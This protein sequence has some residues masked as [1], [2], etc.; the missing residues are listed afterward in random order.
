M[1]LIITSI[2]VRGTIGPAS[3]YTFILTMLAVG[4]VVLVTIL[5]MIVRKGI[6]RARSRNW[7]TAS[8]IIDL[9]SVADV[10]DDASVPSFRATLTYVY[11]NPEEQMGDYSRDF[12]NKDEADAWANSY[13]G[14]T[15]KIYVDPRDPTHSF[16]RDEDL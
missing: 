1:T 3:V 8:A 2:L 15:V 13:K 5:Q 10:T 4:V 12:G 9:V 7:P 6:E 11:R 14:E 16:L